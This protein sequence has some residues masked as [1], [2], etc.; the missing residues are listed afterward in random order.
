MVVV[1]AVV[2][3]GYWSELEALREQQVF[4]CTKRKKKN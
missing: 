4:F 2:V 3:L 1:V